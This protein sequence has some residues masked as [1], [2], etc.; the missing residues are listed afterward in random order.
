MSSIT[1]AV[2][3]GVTNLNKGD[4]K[5][6]QQLLNR[7]RPPPFALVNEDGIIGVQTIAAIEEFQRRVVKMS[8]PDGRVD[9]GG[10]T[11]RMLSEPPASQAKN[12]PGQDFSHPDA[13]KVTLTYGA[14]AAK[15]NSRAEQLMK[16]ILA[17]SGMTSAELTSTL[18]TYRDQARITITQTYKK[19]PDTV[20]LWYGADVLKAC[21]EHL[22]D[23]DGFAKWWQE[24]DTKRGK[25]SSKH[26]SNQAI[27]V[28]PNGDRTKFVAKVKELVAVAGS[29][30]QRII[31]KGELNEPVDHVEFTFKVTG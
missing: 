10:T 4:V 9:P 8:Q 24:Y 15:L 19:N 28:V 11:L 23:I 26:L 22:N 13:A 27:D 16:S 14:N 2:G 31:A 7:H 30:V 5:V 17:S 12:V 25:V 1:K 18:R 6:V 29:G 20:K 3:K 21:K